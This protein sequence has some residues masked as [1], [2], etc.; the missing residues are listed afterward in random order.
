MRHRVAGRKLGLPTDQRM[1]LLKNLVSAV[2]EHEAIE[3]TAGRARETQ[4]MVEKMITGAREDTVHRRR[5]A[6]RVLGGT[7]RGEMLI[8]KLFTEVGP[9]FASRPGGYTRVTK[10]GFRR[11]DSAERVRLELVE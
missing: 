8:A 2:I 10:I 4:K 11:G 9:R 5:L 6:R 3:T 1:A 7:A